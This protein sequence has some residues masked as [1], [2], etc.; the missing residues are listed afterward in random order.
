MKIKNFATVAEM[1]DIITAQTDFDNIWSVEL[2]RKNG[3]INGQF[4]D[5]KGN[6]YLV[7][8][9]DGKVYTWLHSFRLK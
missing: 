5:K 8:I 1:V 3:E 2:E 4:D 9:K 6:T 7:T